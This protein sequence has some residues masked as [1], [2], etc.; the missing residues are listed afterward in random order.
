[1]RNLL[2]ILVFV[3]LTACYK[4][5]TIEIRNFSSKDTL[6]NVFWGDVPMAV[7]L[8][9]GSSTGKTSLY[10]DAQYNFD[11]PESFPVRYSIN[12]MGIKIQITTI[13]NFQ[14]GNEDDLVITIDDSTEV[15]HLNN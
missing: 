14:L 13:H 6:V 15:L 10:E 5:S 2:L 12:N 4:S 7:E 8:T 11:F 1:M 9:P 3:L